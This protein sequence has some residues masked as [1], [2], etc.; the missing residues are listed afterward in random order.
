MPTTYNPTLVLSSYETTRKIEE[1]I[2]NGVRKCFGVPED[3]FFINLN[4]DENYQ[5]DGYVV[6]KNIKLEMKQR[7]SYMIS[8]AYR[9]HRFYKDTTIQKSSTTHSSSVYI[10]YDLSLRY[11]QVF[12]AS[13]IN[14]VFKI[15]GGISQN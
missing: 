3:F 1:K 15:L 13:D 6:N 8:D 5:N 14:R 11:I 2:N 12:V 9:Y 7:Q 10:I 4:P